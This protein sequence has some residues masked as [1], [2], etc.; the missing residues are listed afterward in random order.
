M[1]TWQSAI[2]LPSGATSDR[3]QLAPTMDSI[4]EEVHPS[5]DAPGKAALA[6]S[7]PVPASKADVEKLEKALESSP[8]PKKEEPKKEEPKKE[9]PKKMFFFF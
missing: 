5:F 2:V 9:E 1:P 4:E 8:E 6:S 7:A 3:D